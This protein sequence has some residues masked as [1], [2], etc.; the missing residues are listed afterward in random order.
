MTTV[1]GLPEPISVAILCGGGSRRMGTDKALL[2]LRPGEEPMLGL[3]ID[4]VR[5]LSQD[6]RLIGVGRAGYAQFGL[7]TVPDRF[8]GVGPLGGIATA[9]AACDNDY[10]LIVA[11]DMPF[12]NQSLLMRLASIARHTYDVL[13]PVVAGLDR[14]Q[15]PRHVPQTLHAIYSRRCLPAIERRL[16]AGGRRVT[17]FFPDVRVI[18]LDEAELGVSEVNRRSFFSVDSPAALRQARGEIVG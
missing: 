4:R 14:H 10:C 8:P 9:L 18:T 12:L 15:S 6:V 11:C 5:E 13:V 16:E 17:S 2:P 1:S 7:P 3:V